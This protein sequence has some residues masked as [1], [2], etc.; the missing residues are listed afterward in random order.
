M[1]DVMGDPDPRNRHLG[2]K[3]GSGCGVGEVR[4]MRSTQRIGPP[5]TAGRMLTRAVAH[6]A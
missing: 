1:S 3:R 5:A 6:S 4:V 2:A